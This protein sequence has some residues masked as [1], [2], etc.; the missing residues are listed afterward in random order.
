MSPL[1]FPGFS[2]I[3]PFKALGTAV[4]SLPYSPKPSLPCLKHGDKYC[5]YMTHWH[6]QQAYCIGA[7]HNVTPLLGCLQHCPHTQLC[8]ADRRAEKLTECA[9]ACAQVCTLCVPYP[10][11]SALGST[12]LSHHPLLHPLAVSHNQFKHSQ[13][14]WAHGPTLLVRV[15]LG[16]CVL[17]LRGFVVTLQ[18]QE[19]IAEVILAVALLNE[20]ISVLSLVDT[21]RQKVNHI[22]STVWP[23][24]W[25]ALALYTGCWEKKLF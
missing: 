16:E 11:V 21:H 15:R 2:L 5:R 14:V 19:W 8:K 10:P 1:N 12:Q 3:S 25:K 24:T 18:G 23:L 13:R 6:T 4:V 17:P 20:S 9:R 7:S 22:D